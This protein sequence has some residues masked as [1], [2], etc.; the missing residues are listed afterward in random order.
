MRIVYYTKPCFLDCAVPLAEAL[1]K[2]VKVH[3]V[4]CVQPNTSR[5]TIV[6]MDTEGFKGRVYRAEEFFQDNLSASIYDSL[7]NLEGF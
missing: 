4:V 7:Y 3:L 5:A 1:S 2:V 6:G